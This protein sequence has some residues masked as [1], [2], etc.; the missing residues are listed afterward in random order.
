M[1]NKLLI[2]LA[3]AGC[4]CAP[5]GRAQT[6]ADGLADLRYGRWGV[7][8]SAR[9][10]RVRPGD[11][12]DRYAGGA[13]ANRTP[14]A[15]DAIEAGVYDDLEQLSRRRIA[16]IIAGSDPRSRVGAL[17][18]SYLDE[19]SVERRDDAP[20]RP[21]LKRI[22][23]AGDAVDL[24][25][26]LGAEKASF[27]AQ[28][29]DVASDIDIDDPQ[30]P[31]LYVGQ[32]GLGLPDRD[33]YLSERFARER[34]A[35]RDYA[36]TLLRLTG[37]ADPKGDADRV[38]AFETEIAKAH[39]PR[40]D[41]RDLAKSLRSKTVGDLKREAP[42]LDWDALF[43]GAGLSVRDG[44]RVVIG[45]G[46][47]VARIAA[48]YA[49]MPL[50]T[51]KAW[52]RLR[53]THD[54]AP[55]LSRRFAEPRDVF[56]R[57]LRGQEAQDSREKRALLLVDQLLV[58][59]VG[60]AYAARFFSPQARAAAA[61]VTAD[62]KAAL[63]RRIESS[64]W[65]SA[66]S[67]AVAAAKIDRLEV[68]LGYPDVWRDYGG[69]RLSSADLFGDVSKLRAEAW[70]FDRAQVRAVPDRRRWIIGPQTVNA[71]NGGQE[72][73][74]VL[75]AARL[76]PPNFALSADPAVNYGA[77]GALAGHEI[78]HGFD[79]RGR[80]VDTQGRIRNWWTPQDVST[81]EQRTAVLGAQYDAY[82]SLPGLHLSGR[83]TMGEN[84]ADLVGVL[85]AL[86]AYHA[87]LGG[88]PAPVLD[89]L[90]GDQRF[91]LAYAQSRR[92]KLRDD[93][94]RF[95]ATHDAHAPGRFRVIGPLR[96]V[97]AWYAAFGVAPGDRYY[98]PPEQ[99]AR[100]W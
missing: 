93:D 61:R 46:E 76:Q 66:P 91:F 49:R 59:D 57:S 48:V 97:D 18:R 65:L 70:A 43:S 28:P 38:L 64:D 44:D 92:E 60:R 67:K 14:I 94:L 72:L 77:L 39:L 78:S 24:A 99:R 5:A 33:Y 30:R 87:S 83:L 50:P 3:A 79:N 95:K 12:F 98:L 100:I 75:P 19:A 47:A 55:F 10:L 11:D 16:A 51:L 13:W 2:A 34:A 25:R 7:D 45:Q 56:D 31:C 42:G 36:E 40:A 27:G 63:R 9:D 73:K 23:R 21:L 26:T 69:V 86:D 8:L 22:D 54:A 71:Y 15:A 82:E 29:V 68:M 90:T 20:L 17:Y 74:I 1:R 81:F 84:I 53:T 32:G 4:L 80:L 35:Y 41:A 58:D 62:V 6:G 88:K 37:D 89:G 85:A 96:N 52:A